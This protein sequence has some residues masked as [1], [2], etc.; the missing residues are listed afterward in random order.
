M[1]SDRI[2]ETLFIAFQ[3]F[4]NIARTEI[5]AM[6]MKAWLETLPIHSYDVK[7][8]RELIAES[9][10]AVAAAETG[11]EVSTNGVKNIDKDEENRT[12]ANVITAARSDDVIGAA[13]E[14]DADVKS[15]EKD[16]VSAVSSQELS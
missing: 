3:V 5:E 13:P 1:Y 6:E 7:S 4:A 14:K 2:D 9:A 12:N 11:V 15:S 16:S 8:G 10:A